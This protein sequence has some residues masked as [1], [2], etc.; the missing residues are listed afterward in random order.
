MFLFAWICLFV[1]LPA[2]DQNYS[3]RYERIALQFYGGVSCSQKT[4]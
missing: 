4:K 2:C 1:F 3:E